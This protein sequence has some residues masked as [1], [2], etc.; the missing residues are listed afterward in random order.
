VLFFFFV[1]T[2]IEKKCSRT[3]QNCS[4]AQRTRP[5]QGEITSLFPQGLDG[6]DLDCTAIQG[7]IIEQNSAMDILCQMK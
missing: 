6:S 1:L 4:T 5:L 7:S 2:R 3:R